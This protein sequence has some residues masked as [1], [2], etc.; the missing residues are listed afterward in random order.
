MFR[1]GLMVVVTYFFRDRTQGGLGRERGSI[2]SELHNSL[3]F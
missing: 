3:L 2:P 1:G